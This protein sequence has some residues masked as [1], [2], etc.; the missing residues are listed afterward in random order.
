M[1]K[2]TLLES[3]L[4]SKFKHEI[5]K[6]S[7]LSQNEIRVNLS[8]EEDVKMWK[9]DFEQLSGSNF[10]VG[11]KYPNPTRSLF[12]IEYVCRRSKKDHLNKDSDTRRKQVKLNEECPSRIDITIKLNTESTRKKDKFVRQGTYIA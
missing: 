9:S 5:T 4:P 10:K 11:H 2:V 7:P 1:A 3:F 6:F 12:H 8:C